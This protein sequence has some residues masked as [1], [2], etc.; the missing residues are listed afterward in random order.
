MK[1]TILSIDIALL[2]EN[3]TVGQLTSN[4]N[5]F[6]GN[7]RKQRSAQVQLRN[8]QYIP[9][10]DNGVLIVKAKTR[11]SDKDYDTVIQFEKVRYVKPGTQWAVPLQTEGQELYIMP[12]KNMGNY[13]QVHCT[14]M[15]FYWRFANYNKKN[16]SLLGEPPQPYVK[17]T[18][19]EPLNPDQVPGNCKHLQKLADQLRLERLLK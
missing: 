9:A 11:S 18:D 17:K 4:T 8:V 19:R 13:V 10:V 14:C 3:S 6:F 1:K 12:L 2:L 7:G 16:D 5:V 15:D